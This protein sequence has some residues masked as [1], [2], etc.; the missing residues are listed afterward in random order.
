MCDELDLTIDQFSRRS[1][2]EALH[3]R[4]SELEEQLRWIPVS[5]RLPKDGQQVLISY[6][7][8]V[9]LTYFEADTHYLD[10]DYNVVKC[11]GFRIEENDY[12]FAEGLEFP[13]HWMPAPKPVKTNEQS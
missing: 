12:L 4:I 6:D 13:T 8:Y 9:F 7:G 1:I 11:R 3:E 10:D 5:E 2:E